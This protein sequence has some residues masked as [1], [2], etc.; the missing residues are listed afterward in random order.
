MAAR[1][2]V[3]VRYIV[4]NVVACVDFYTEHFGSTVGMYGPPASGSTRSNRR[5]PLSATLKTRPQL[6]KA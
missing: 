2:I 5:P 6:P 4:Q 3:S 1:D